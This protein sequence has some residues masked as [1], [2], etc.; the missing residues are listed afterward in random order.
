MFVHPS[1][2][3]NCPRQG[4][5]LFSLWVKLQIS[6][7]FW[8]KETLKYELCGMNFLYKR[9]EFKSVAK[10]PM[11]RKGFHFFLGLTMQPFNAFKVVFE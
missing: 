2:E 10:K 6:V 9:L 3:T 7:F 4:L 11:S 5:Q 1:L 8:V